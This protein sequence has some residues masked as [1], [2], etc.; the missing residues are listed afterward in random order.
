MNR[1]KKSICQ[2]AICFGVLVMM[3]SQMS[4]DS[5]EPLIT[6]NDG[7]HIMLIGGNLCS[8]MMNYGS[9][10]TEMHLRYPEKRLYIRNMCDGGDTPGFRPHSGRDTPWAF[11]GAEVYH[12]LLYTSPS[13]RDR[14]KSRMP[15]S[16]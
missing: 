8:R 12:C 2:F 16:A 4:C 1:A 6:I 13:P 7:D 14:Q 9:F 10:E 15:S 3:F 11:E 5:S